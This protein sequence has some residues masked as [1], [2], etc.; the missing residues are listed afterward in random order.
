MQLAK[1]LNW[2]L[3]KQMHRDIKYL[4]SL[5]FDVKVYQMNL[6]FECPL[7]LSFINSQTNY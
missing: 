5:L 2:S 7:N 4:K 1:K 3:E 6:G